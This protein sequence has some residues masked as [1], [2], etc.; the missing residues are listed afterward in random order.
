MKCYLT[1][2]MKTKRTTILHLKEDEIL[3][4]MSYLSL[5]DLRSFGQTCKQLN[6]VFKRYIRGATTVINESYTSNQYGDFWFDGPF[7]LRWINSKYEKYYKSIF[8]SGL[9]LSLRFNQFL[10]VIT[11][12]LVNVQYL[13]LDR[14]EDITDN[15]A[16]LLGYHLPNLKTL[17]LFRLNIRDGG[18]TTLF[19]RLQRLKNLFLL[20]MPCNGS[21]FSSLGASI[22]SLQLVNCYRIEYEFFQL[23]GERP[24]LQELVVTN[25]LS[26]LPIDD[27][28]NNML[29][30]FTNLRTL[31]IHFNV[32]SSILSYLNNFHQLENI[33]FCF[34]SIN[35]SHISN[36]K[37]LNVK[38]AT[39]A[40][41]RVSDNDLSLTVKCFPN[42]E[43]LS[44]IVMCEALKITYTSN[45][46]SSLKFLKN[47]TFCK[48]EKWHKLTNFSNLFDAPNL[49]KV[50]IGNLA[51]KT[52]YKIVENLCST[53]EVSNDEPRL[54]V[55]LAT[56]HYNKT[57]LLNPAA[58][59]LQI[60]PRLTC[61][62]FY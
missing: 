5:K 28:F 38:T 32:S 50:I 47:L 1:N 35:I 22:K 20:N 53:R 48:F 41:K 49:R 4:I 29:N 58:Y 36:L 15:D 52:V 54:T 11:T 13:Y 23:L 21:C 3:K 33:K 26:R 44:L 7:R 56:Q 40:F 14:C 27:S 18:L 51:I 60:I 12:Y 57:V 61:G 9:S 16:Y 59:D 19:Q 2:A 45:A 6:A 8:S 62:I 37:V 43:H 42:V 46:I 31:N 34:A 10:S 24:A 30:T 55:V 25:E 17:C 39:L